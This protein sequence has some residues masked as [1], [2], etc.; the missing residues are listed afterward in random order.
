[1]DT[2]LENALSVSTTDLAENSL[3]FRL[4]E[5]VM[6]DEPIFVLRGFGKT[7]I[8]TLKQKKTN[9]SDR[10][11]MKSSGPM[12]GFGRDGSFYILFNSFLKTKKK[13]S[14]KSYNYWRGAGKPLFRNI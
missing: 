7:K 11:T 3:R 12:R 4:T 13:T 8:K 5:N 10:F 9:D 2:W 6:E 14:T 1:M